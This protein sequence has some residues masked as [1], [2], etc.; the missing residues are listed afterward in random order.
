VSPTGVTGEI[1][2]GG[3]G[4]GRGY[5]GDAR[6]T[7][8]KFVPDPYVKVGG[9]RMYRTGDRGRYVEGGRIEYEGRRD[10]Q[11]KV[12]GHRVEL[13]EIEEVLR[14][15][16]GVREAVVIVREDDPWQKRLVGYVAG[17]QEWGVEGKRRRLPNGMVIAEQNKNETEYLY[18]EIFRKKSYF[19]HG[20]NLPQDGCVFDI[21]ANIGLF[22]LFVSQ[23]RKGA[24]VYAFEPIKPIYE[25]LRM[26]AQLYGGAGVKVYQVGL[27]EEEGKEWYTYYRGYSMMSGERRYATATEDIEVIKSYLRNEQ[28]SG[29]R[30]SLLKEADDI[31]SYRFEEE[32]YEC[33]VKRLT[34]VIREEGVERIDILKVDVQRA[35]M[36]VLRGLG[37]ADWKKINQIVMEVHDQEGSQTEGRLEEIRRLLKAKGYKVTIEQDELLSG[38]DRYNLYARRLGGRRKIEEQE[39]VE[40]RGDETWDEISEEKLRKYVRESLP[41]YMTPAVIVVMEELPL[42]RNGKID[43]GALPRPEEV[44]KRSEI[45][46]SE[47]RNAYEEIINGVWKAVLKVERVGRR[48]SFFEIGGD[49]LSTTQVIARVR[50]VFG[51]EIGI[52]SIFNNPTIE[53]LARVVE[54]AMRAGERDA[55]PPLV[56]A[57]REERLPLSFAQQRLWFIDQLEPGSAVYNCPGAVK[58][59]GRLNLEALERVVNE[60]VRRHEVLRTRIEVEEGEPAQVIDEWEPRRLE[61]EDLT[62]LPRET[63]EEE[64]G[65]RL[66]EEAEIGFD[67][68]RGPL[69]RV[70]VLKVQEDEHVALFTMHHIVCDAWSMQILSREVGTLYQEYSAGGVGGGSP[71]AELPIQYADFA[72]WQREWLKGEVLEE[73]LAYWREQLAGMEDLELPTDHPRPPA[74][75]Y[76]GASRSFVV[77]R[78]LAE[79]LRELSRREGATLFMTLL[80]GFNVLMSRYSWQTDVAIGTDIANRNRA[81]IEGLI[82]FFVNQLVLRVEVRARESFVDFVKRVRDVC[83]GAYAHQ[84]LPFEKLVE[85]LRPERDLS[86]SPLFQVKLIWQNAPGEGLELGEVRPVS[87][88]GGEVRTA[89]DARSARFDLT[90]S[91]TDG[92]HDLVGAV[93][94]SRDLFEEGTI[95]RLISHYTNVLRGIVDD[96]ES[97]IFSLSLLSAE[98][99]SQIVVGWNETGKPYP[100]DRRIHEL[101]AEQAERTPERIAL[102]YEG[103]Q[104]SYGE[105]NRRANQLGNYLRRLGVGPEVV[106]G[107][108][109][110]RSMEMVVAVLGALKA[111][112]AYLPLDPGTP[113]ERMGY[114]LED[115][116]AVVV[117]TDGRLEERLPAVM[118]HAVLMD[119]EREKISKE[120]ESGLESEVGAKNLAY[121]IYTSGSSGRPKGVMIEHRGLRNLAEAQK[122][123]F[124]LEG[125]SRVLQFASLSFDASISEIFTTLISGGRLHVCAQQSLT[126]AS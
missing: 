47:H 36:N 111:G 74:P 60:V 2:I 38:T 88:D 113:A 25:T 101:I 11:V 5:I 102:V 28:T 55:A 89:N 91:I 115:A 76:R 34:D 6:Q 61:V 67:L 20:I 14:S 26:N 114:M 46:E 77:E 109:L 94:Y 53:G 65:R 104:V 1:Y 4:L 75:S 31:L 29:M 9:E 119:E 85:E 68:S 58:L 50:D 83:L 107:V 10:G 7:A 126:R 125:Q 24:R 70:K 122:A 51:V 30:N 57:S 16:P 54:E 78:E 19:K 66:R 120:S 82:G 3:E 22:T 86:R 21:G 121:V 92:G 79:R 39:W 106:V 72:V 8:E 48:D 42:T 17:R 84:D 99:R 90:V 15:Y 45:E 32:Q 33:Q 49:S 12:R 71:L 35:E 117:L 87:G 27:G 23:N 116:G 97:P 59:T 81:E 43:R 52:R 44:K 37:E 64:I 56:R 41:D 110:E 62:N 112:G 69:L 105:L 95:E 124:G 96:S 118:A 80:G 13:G 108:C 40:M 63:R 73:K 93:I 103:Q 98:E 123:A 18:E 100:D